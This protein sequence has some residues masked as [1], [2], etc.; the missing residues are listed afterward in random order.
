MASRILVAQIGAAHGLRG[1]VRLW[2]FTENP[3][4]VRDYGVL[5]SE[6]GGQ[7]FEI[8]AL[9][10]AKDFLVARLRGI[11]DRTAAEALR[12]VQLY[13]PRDRLPKPPAEEF[14]HADLVG[15]AV[16]AADG[17]ELGSV[18]A[19]HN[20]GAG[21]LIEV[22]PLVGPTVL[23]PFTEAV[24]PEVDVA[25]GRLIADPP[26]GAFDKDMPSLEG[27]DRPRSRR[28]EVESAAR[29]SPLPGK[30]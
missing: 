7:T 26:D 15:L 9:R 14:Y 29:P 5:E 12:N 16:V 23:L 20:F 28:D 19:V 6:D 11:R 22:R 1:E 8:E 18:I 21:D 4:A 25:A 2:S 24:V 13:V 10:P 3:L 17:R 30:D 27:E